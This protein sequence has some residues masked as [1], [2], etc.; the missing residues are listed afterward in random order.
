MPVQPFPGFR[1]GSRA[2]LIPNAF[3][4]AILPVIREPA[5]LIVSCYVFFVLGRQH[6]ALRAVSEAR[7]S[8]EPPLM[9]ALAGLAAGGPESLRLGLALALARGTLRRMVDDAG[10]TVYA[11]NIEGAPRAPTPTAIPPEAVLAAT[12]NIFAL[13]EDNIGSISPLLVDELSE[14]EQSYPL[15]WIE[16]AFREAV[17]R[18]RRNW[19]YISRILARWQIEGP[20]Y[21]ASGGLSA[22]SPAG[23]RR[24]LA[25]PY[26]HLVE[27]G[28]DG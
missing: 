2:T 4:T 12:P 9:Q 1:A 15:S 10:E 26:R 16:A 5:E 25:G 22:I 6:G 27:R 21:E 19:R 3:F 28:P 14:A 17:A 7:L 24:S 23:R 11:L 13:Y 18:N 8:A 20:D